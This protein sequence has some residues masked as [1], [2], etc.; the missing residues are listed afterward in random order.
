[1]NEEKEVSDNKQVKEE[2]IQNE[3]VTEIEKE[4]S[5]LDKEQQ[6]VLVKTITE[7]YDKELKEKEDK[8]AE[9]LKQL[10]EKYNKSIKE[11]EQQKV[12][13]EDIVSQLSKKFDAFTEKLDKTWAQYEPQSKGIANTQQNPFKDKDPKEIIDKIKSIDDWNNNPEVKKLIEKDFLDMVNR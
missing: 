6:E 2:T 12:E 1:M 7:K 10:N 3:T 11:K 8:Y 13:Y 5:K 9:E 4:I